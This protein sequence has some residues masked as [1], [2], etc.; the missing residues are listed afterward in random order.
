MLKLKL[1]TLVFL[2]SFSSLAQALTC[3]INNPILSF[4][5]YDPQSEQSKIGTATV[6]ISCFNM[7]AD[8]HYALA[9]VN[10]NSILSMM[11]GD[12]I[13]YYQLYTSSDHE[14]IWNEE[15]I[16]TGIV[17][18]NSGKGLDE[19]II[20]GRVLPGQLGAKF[21]TYTGASNPVIINLSY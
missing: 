17:Q 18:N 19:K 21:G 8:T 13:I 11:K 10:K 4:E 2:L 7:K 9:L 3:K 20:Y 14:K 12:E 15:N 5:K 1:I 16:I 6:T